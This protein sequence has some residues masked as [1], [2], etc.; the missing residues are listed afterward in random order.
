LTEKL[1]FYIAAYEAEDRKSKGGGH[2]HEGE[3][4]ETLE[5]SIDEAMAMITDG[6][7]IDGKTIML[8]QHAVLSIFR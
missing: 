7:I 4:I 6:R 8:L 5:V 3:D 1:H 2:E